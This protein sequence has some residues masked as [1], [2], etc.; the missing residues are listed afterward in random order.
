MILLQQKCC[1]PFPLSFF[2]FF[3]NT[4]CYA[5]G[6]GLKYYSHNVSPHRLPTILLGP[7]RWR[8]LV[9]AIY[10]LAQKTRRFYKGLWTCLGIFVNFESRERVLSTAFGKNI[11]LLLFSALLLFF[12][13]VWG[14]PPQS[15]F[16][17][18]VIFSSFFKARRKK[19]V[20]IEPALE[21]GVISF[22]IC[23]FG[24]F[25]ARSMTRPPKV[26]EITTDFSDAVGTTGLQR[27]S[28]SD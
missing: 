9:W 2:V 18:I 7:L 27:V 13:F 25:N 19:C 23:C 28:P 5:W 6:G 8:Q 20:R 12:S 26:A 4:S 14:K 15:E 11:F 16:A 17:Q 10:T 21:F 24:V 3:R 1:F 22:F